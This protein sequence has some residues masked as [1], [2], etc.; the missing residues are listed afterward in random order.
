[1]TS[2]ENAHEFC[3]G[4][5]DY[6]MYP[7]EIQLEQGAHVLGY[8]VQLKVLFPDGRTGYSTRQAKELMDPEALGMISTH[9]LAVERDLLDVMNESNHE[10]GT[11]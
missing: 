3:D 2:S 1:M 6:V 7:L 11:A 9:K 8:T 4:H 10:D 5:R